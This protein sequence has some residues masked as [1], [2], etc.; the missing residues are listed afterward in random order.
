VL[1]Y[2]ATKG[3]FLQD[4]PTIGEIVRQSVEEKLGIR[5]R[6]ESSEYQSWNHSLGNAMFH[7]MNSPDIPSEAGVA[8][9]YR[10]HGRQQRI[11][12]MVSGVDAANASQLILVE[13]KQWNSVESS[14]LTEHVRT[15]LNGGLRD[16]PHPSYQS[17]S[18][19]RLLQD[20][21]E[22]VVADPITVSPTV[23]LHNLLSTGVVKD[24]RY[25]DL[26]GKAPV[27]G[28][29]EGALLREFICSRITRGDSADVIKRVEASPVHASKQLVEALESMLRGNE[30][31]VLI[32]EQKTAFENILSLIRDTPKDER[33]AILVKGGPGTGKS[34]IAVNALVAALNQKLNARY[35]TK[36]AAPRA[37]YQAKLKG[38]RLEVATNNLF[39]SSDSFHA[40]P[41]N[42]YDVLLV[43]EAHRLVEKSGFYRNL[44]SNQIREIIEASRVN[45]FFAD[46]SQLVTWRDI[47]TLENIRAAAKD[48][49]VDVIEMELTAQFRCAGSTDYLNW[50]DHTLGLGGDPNASLANSEFRVEIFDS[51]SELRDFIF[52]KNKKNNK[53]RLLAGYCWDWVSKKDPSKF[54]IEFPGTDFAMKWNLTSDGS[55][56]MIRPSSINEV[57][58]IHTCQG[59]E[60]DYVGV[61]IG[62]DLELVDG[63]LRGNPFKRSKG[64]KSMDGFKNAYASNPD[65]ALEKA[66][67]L[68]RNTYRT[69]MT[70]GMI[71]VGM[72]CTNRDVADALKARIVT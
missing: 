58:C 35:V 3:D 57:G 38:K 37:V 24:K 17:W 63:E 29:G 64:D 40:A 26:L 33:S 13:L 53:S 59:L 19:S 65:S 34:V 5:I 71:G 18:Y 9:E 7:V 6:P 68:I 8:I 67:I 1:A 48:A 47:G 36:N 62:D 20:F 10:L 11:D 70:R 69:L 54:D 41:P 45:V 72:F 42:S 56:W 25:S 2:V 12:F 23:Y 46:E 4:A 28:G 14:D 21:Y 32:D 31:F 27:F 61:I 52:E 43:D 49:G 15:Y 39:V 22:Y 66:D 50:L 16:V 44:G 55:E 60:G 30:E 51:P